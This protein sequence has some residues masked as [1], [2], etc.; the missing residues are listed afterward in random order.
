MPE[1]MKNIPFGRPMAVIFHM[2]F[3]GGLGGMMFR[4]PSFNRLMTYWSTNPFVGTPDEWRVFWGLVGLV[5]VL[6][7]PLV[8]E[9]WSRRLVI[10][11]L[12]N[13]VWKLPVQTTMWSVF[14]VLMFVFRR[15]SAYDFIYFQF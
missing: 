4:E 1:W 13:S 3:F 5:L 11:K 2:G 14:I 6:S 8:I 12:E 10:P 15:V 7:S 9:H